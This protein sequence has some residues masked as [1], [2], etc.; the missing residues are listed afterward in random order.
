ML[1]EKQ[2][3]CNLIEVYGKLLTQRQYDVMV[4]YYYNDLSL[5]EIAINLGITKQA[6]KDAV[7]KAKHT[8]QSYESILHIVKKKNAFYTLMQNKDAMQVGEYA[9]QLENLFKE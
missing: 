4:E 1:E 5:N 9:T 3:I 8:L 6:V 2:L 7:D